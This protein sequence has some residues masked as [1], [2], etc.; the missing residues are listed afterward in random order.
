MQ[1]RII[2]SYG[3][4][5]WGILG[6]VFV[7]AVGI[8]IYAGRRS[9]DSRTAEV[10]DSDNKNK[11]EAAATPAQAGTDK[12]ADQTLPTDDPRVYSFLQGPK[13]Y[14][15]GL[16]WSGKWGKRRYD[17][18]K[19]GAF[20]C[21]FCCMANIYCT[22]TAYKANPV[23]IY[24]CS[25]NVTEYTGGQAIGWGHM[26]QT[27]EYMGFTVQSGRKPKKYKTYKKLV[28]ESI[29]SIALVSSYDSEE[30]WTNTP[31]HY[32]VLFGYDE[33]TDTVMITDSGDPS[34]NRARVGLRVV[35][36]SLKKSSDFQYLNIMSYDEA[37]DRLKHKTAGGIWYRPD[38][39][40]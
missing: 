16:T 19:F 18:A 21:G 6:I 14:K 34:H 2:S 31:G 37:A 28:K 35:W 11:S 39:L 10:S 17:G 8:G 3:L 38:Y 23:T 20:G 26:K 9:H 40:K 30:Y 7:L 12:A 33:A 1:R 29:C 4:I 24:K 15:K 13:S 27:L 22:E 5:F 25:K 36:R 32:I